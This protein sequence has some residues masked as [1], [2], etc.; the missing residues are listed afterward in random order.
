MSKIEPSV[1]DSVSTYNIR[2]SLD[3]KF[4][5]APVKECIRLILMEELGDKSYRAE[6]VPVWTKSIADA[7][8]DKI[9]E[10]GFERYKMVVQVVIGEQRG[11]GVKIGSRCL[12]DSDTDN[13]A[14]DI[15]MNDSLFCVATAFA[16]YYY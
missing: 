10:L 12:W 9:K 1:D 2:P 13:Y 6:D 16:T 7:I 15:F 11:E 8:R 3:Q 14:S 4:R 5:S